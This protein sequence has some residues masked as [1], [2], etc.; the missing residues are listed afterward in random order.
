[1]KYLMICFKKHFFAYDDND[2]LDKKANEK[3]I[4]WLWLFISLWQSKF[5][6]TDSAVEFL[7]N[8]LILFFK[9]FLQEEWCI[10]KKIHF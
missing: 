8:L 7:L 2:T 5:N 3:L 1:M 10:G 4:K 9:V 6:I